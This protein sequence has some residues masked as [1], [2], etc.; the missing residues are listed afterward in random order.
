MFD[1]F[2]EYY[3]GMAQGISYVPAQITTVFAV[4]SVVYWRFGDYQLDKIMLV[5]FTVVYACF[6][7][8]TRRGSAWFAV[9]CTWR[10]IWLRFPSQSL[11]A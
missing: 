6:F 10:D 11:L 8:S 4:T 2:L 5:L 9:W 3:L 7:Q 1:Y